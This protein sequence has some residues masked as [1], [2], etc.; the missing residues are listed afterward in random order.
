MVLLVLAVLAAGAIMFRISQGP[1]EI[2]F[3][4]KFIESELSDP[5]HNVALRIGEVYLGWDKDESRPEVSLK[6]IQLLNTQQNRLIVSV[7]SAEVSF[8]RSAIFIGKLEPRS[9]IVQAPL[10]TLIRDS[11]GR[12]RLALDQKAD[13]DP[14]DKGIELFDLLDELSRPASEIPRDWP[15]RSLRMI[16]ISDARMMVEDHVLG[17]S[18]L[19][20]KIELAIS[21]PREQAIGAS[22]SLWLESARSPEP[23]LKLTAAYLKESRSL[24]FGLG[25]NKLRASFVASKLP[26]LSWLQE[27]T[28]SLSGQARAQIDSSMNLTGMQASLQSNNGLILIPDVYKKPIPYKSLALDFEYAAATKTFTLLDSPI[29]FTDDFSVVLSG[30]AVQAAE[31]GI[32][33]PLKVK[34]KNLPQERIAEYWPAVLEGD[35]SEEW[36]LH[37]LSKGRLHDAV[38]DVVL[39]AAKAP[40]EDEPDEM[41]WKVRLAD[42]N[43][44]FNLSDMT[45][46]YRAPMMKLEHADGHGKFSMADDRLTIDVSKGSMGDLTVNEGRVIIDTVIGKTVGKA[47][48]DIDVAGPLKTLIKYISEEPIFVKVPTTIEKVAGTAKLKVNIQFPTLAVLPAEKI[49]VEA[50]GQMQNVLLPGLVHDLDVSGGPINV[51]VKDRQVAIDGKAKL[52]GVDTNFTFDQYFE[53]KDKDY[54]AKVVANIIADEPLRKKFGLDLASWVTG[55]VPAKVVYTDFGGG[56]AQVETEVDATPATLM[57]KPM[58][59][60]KVPGVAGKV[61]ATAILQGGAI[62]RIEK[63]NVT[64]PDASVEDGSMTFV[65]SGKES[66]LTGGTLPKAKLKDTQVA[67]GFTVTP[68][69][70]MTINIKGAFLDATPFLENDKKDEPYSGPALKANVE[71]DKMRTS[72]TDAINNAKIA[73]SMDNQGVANLLHVDANVGRGSLIFRY[74]PDPTGEKMTLTV[75]AGDAGAALQA[76]DVY[77]NIRGGVLAVKGAS[78]PGGDKKIVIGKAEITNFKVVNAPV[79]ARLVNAIS[80]TG[81]L[82]L[83]GSDGIEFSRLESDFT[84][85]KKKGG[86]VF[87]VKDGRTSGS[88][89][90]LTFEGTVDRVDDMMNINGTIVPVSLVNDI[91]SGIPLIGDILSGGSK[92]GVF[93]ATYTVR[94]PTK[95]PETSVNPLSILTP[96]FLRRI[97]FE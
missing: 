87:A 66:L 97:F 76:F 60:V 69:K 56:K 50:T 57:V 17:Q 12:V 20:P 48:I 70:L 58:N 52:D 23:A 78:V 9:I 31:G 11:D 5:A 62:T 35:P 1:I 6:N 54:A 67:V 34:V 37:R 40:R 24:S 65:Q 26:D 51:K 22:A 15:L 28:V 86:D 79:L 95:Q 90:G 41:K 36:A 7:R 59:Y 25:L 61:T 77:E 84:W 93:A 46:D 43:A 27:Q 74:Q 10:I 3:A 89:M 55:A 8:S 45:V 91:L 18:W 16:A 49:D 73:F 30:S 42:L 38:I 96:G 82:Q 39:D 75:D 2:G 94:G 32:H 53:S 19:V 80:L 21:R 63:L 85:T 33:A 64:T 13:K 88:S 71:V 92:G 47:T 4:K 68:A 14:A 72:A 83:L 29:V 44:D 81:V